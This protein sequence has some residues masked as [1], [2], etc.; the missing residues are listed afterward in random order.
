MP[1][2]RGMATRLGHSLPNW[3]V[4]AVSVLSPI[5]TKERTT[6][7]VRKVPWKGAM[8][9][10]P[11]CSKQHCAAWTPRMR[12]C[13][14]LV[15]LICGGINAHPLPNPDNSSLSFYW[16]NVPSRWDL[17][18][19]ADVRVSGRCEGGKGR[20]AIC[21]IALNAQCNRPWS[22]WWLRQRTHSRSTNIWLPRTS[23]Y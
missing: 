14:N 17:S 20:D 19:P 23:R 11:H 21:P 3:A 22:A 9:R 15:G 1:R 2:R 6:R 4:R 13:N 12:L 10:L 5:A 7:E 16:I 18:E 8:K